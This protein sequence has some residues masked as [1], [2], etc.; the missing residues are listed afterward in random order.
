ME[1]L[2]PSPPPLPPA[3]P[4]LCQAQTHTGTSARSS[5]PSFSFE[6]L[7]FFALSCRTPLSAQPCSC[8]LAS[9][10]ACPTARGF[11]C[12]VQPEDTE[13]HPPPFHSQHEQVIGSISRLTRLQPGQPQAPA[14]LRPDFQVQGMRTSGF[15]TTLSTQ[16]GQL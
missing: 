6:C 3:S 11:H 13:R 12:L 10:L 5:S 16:G 1:L 9:L 8:G 4:G 14:Q 7:L 15:W 2:E